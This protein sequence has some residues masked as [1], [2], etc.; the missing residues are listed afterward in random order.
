MFGTVFGRCFG[1]GQTGY[2]R[3]MN[4]T[5]SPTENTPPTIE[6][7]QVAAT[8]PTTFETQ[9]SG[10]IADRLC[11]LPGVNSV[12][13]LHGERD[14]DALTPD[15]WLDQIR[16]KFSEERRPIER[17]EEALA[18]GETLALINHDGEQTTIDA[19]TKG[20]EAA[21]AGWAFN[22]AELSWSELRSP[23]SP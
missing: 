5:D 23:R 10:S 8:F 21:K 6:T 9:Y 11:A 3:H 4:A 18:N 15:S 7:N 17:L 13:F 14:A 2:L 20:L 19:I 1:T 12:E 16:R 22:F